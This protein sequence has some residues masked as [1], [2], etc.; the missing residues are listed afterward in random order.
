MH[1]L[2]EDL[3]LCTVP[4][5]TAR[6]ALT[7]IDAISGAGAFNSHEIDEDAATLYNKVCTARARRVHGALKGK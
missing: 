2:F 1:F 3:P 5:K 7:H 6:Y 4:G